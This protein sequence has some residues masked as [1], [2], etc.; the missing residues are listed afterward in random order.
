MHSNTASIV[1]CSKGF[2][3]VPAAIHLTQS[4]VS[5]KEPASLNDLQTLSQHTHPRTTDIEMT[6]LTPTLGLFQNLRLLI[7]S[8]II[9]LLVDTAGSTSM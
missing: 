1:P 7:C 8:T 6:A 9:S 4:L 2:N 5:S 3:L